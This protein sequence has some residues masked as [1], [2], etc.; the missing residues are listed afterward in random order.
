MRW[1]YYRVVDVVF[2]GDWLY[3]TT[4]YYEDLFAFR[5]GKDNDMAR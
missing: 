2:L 3:E 5:I 1:V 4:P